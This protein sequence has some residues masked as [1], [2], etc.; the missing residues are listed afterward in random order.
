MVIS[1][2]R[3][4][5]PFK[6]NGDGEMKYINFIILVSLVTMFIGIVFGLLSWSPILAA[7]TTSI[8]VFVLGMVMLTRK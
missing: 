3:S 4:M 8:L 2:I 5:M 1:S 7:L 6:H